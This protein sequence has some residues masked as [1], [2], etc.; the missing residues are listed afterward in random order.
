MRL[1]PTVMQVQV[2]ANLADRDRFRD[3]SE[4]REPA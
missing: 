2:L 4:A 3:L 1:S